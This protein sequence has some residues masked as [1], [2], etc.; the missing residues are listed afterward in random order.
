M[1]DPAY[2]AYNATGGGPPPPPPPPPPGNAYVPPVQPPPPGP[3]P[4]PRQ[5]AG[6]YRP[7][8]LS[9]PLPG[10]KHAPPK[11]RGDYSEV[12]RFIWLYERLC[13][14][15]NVVLDEERCRG[16][17]QYCSRSVREFIEA[18]RNYTTPN[19][20]LL[21]RDLENY[22]D[23]ARYDERYQKKDLVAL[24]KKTRGKRMGDLR[25]WKR[26]T[27]EFI[28]IAGWLR[29]EGRLTEREL[30]I[31]FWTGIG[32]RLRRRVEDRLV[33]SDPLYDRREP[34]TM[35][36][37]NVMAEGILQRGK[38]DEEMEDSED[39]YDSDWSG[40]S[41][42][43]SESSSDEDERH[44]RKSSTKKK[45]KPKAK[46]KTVRFEVDETKTTR[47]TRAG[48]KATKT[49]G[50]AVTGMIQQMRSMSL[51][52]ER[53][54]L[55]Y[56]QALKLDSDVASI[57]AA[58]DLSN[59]PAQVLVSPPTNSYSQPARYTPPPAQY[60]QQYSPPPVQY[61]PPPAQYSSP[62]RNGCFGCG[63]PSHSL[64]NCGILRGMVDS[65]VVRR[66]WRGQYTRLDGSYIERLG[67]E[68]VVQAIE[69]EQS[70]Y[71][72][73]VDW[74]NWMQGEEPDSDDEI[75]SEDD[76]D[77]YPVTRSSNGNRTTRKE[78]FDGVHMPPRTNTKSSGSHRPTE[79]KGSTHLRPSQRDNR[80][81]IVPMDTQPTFLPRHEDE[82]L[83]DNEPT[84]QP[85]TRTPPVESSTR[86]AAV[87]KTTPRTSVISRIVDPKTVLGQVLSTPVQLAFGDILGVSRELSNL[88]ADSI[89]MKN[90]KTGLTV[91]RAALPGTPRYVARAPESRPVFARSSLIEIRVQI[92]G[93]DVDAIVDTGS[94]LN[95]VRRDVW[96]DL[97]KK[98][99]DIRRATRMNDVNGGDG[100]LLGLVTDVHLQ[101][102]A[103]VAPA[104]MYVA[105]HVPF[106]LLLGR[107]WQLQNYVSIDERTRGTYLVF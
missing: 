73:P 41:D 19:W 87:T 31:H 14:E 72:S 8:V 7:S 66:G 78:V 35:E 17:I 3:P 56:F 16:I 104:D 93:Q 28:K 24:V 70:E 68:T 103:V 77:V 59:S 90:T 20:L 65:G 38:F 43:E 96:E 22:Y 83:E 44:S 42:S 88:L 101:F 40:Q 84:S 85:S 107:P 39:S 9:L 49:D 29:H 80:T 4:V 54:P 100:A 27:R 47:K 58:P 62:N 69:R 25:A 94:Q 55:L 26:Y 60:Q 74:V 37:V 95:I 86:K 105:E 61:S 2:P 23:A 46:G 92:E 15:H 91:A 10:T 11:F 57:V 48:S 75:D 63:D 45:S 89:K 50:E 36:N 18:L 53:Y 51:R 13:V 34:F 64:G 32:R 12:A 76:F 81:R 5:A 67:N 6:A 82:F 99:V 1:P 97:V 79:K 102:G 52:D 71:D 106:M 21:R 30:N 33:A 98:P